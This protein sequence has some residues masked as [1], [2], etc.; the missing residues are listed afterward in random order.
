MADT[1]TLDAAPA[2]SAQTAPVIVAV[3]DGYAQTKL[4]NR[5]ARGAD[6]VTRSLLLTSVRQGSDTFSGLD[7]SAARGS[8]ES[9]GQRFNASPLVA[10]ENTRYDDFHVSALNRVA[11]HHALHESG[12]RGRTVDLICGLPLSSYYSNGRRNVDFINKKKTNLMVPVRALD[13]GPED[14]VT[15]SSV[16]V[17]SQGICAWVDW[18]IDE[19]LQF[20]PEATEEDAP[21]GIIDI[22]GRTTDFAVV[23]LDQG[24]P[25]ID[26][27]RSGSVNLGVLD[28]QRILERE[29]TA[30]FKG[31]EKLARKEYD[32][33]VREGE[34][35]I[36]GRKEDVSDLVDRGVREIGA[37]IERV[38][39]GTIGSGADL[40][41]V[42]FVGGGAQLFQKVS[43]IYP[44]GIVQEDPEFSNARGMF[45]YAALQAGSQG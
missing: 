26:H 24:K 38:V 32:R 18:A 29:I 17:Y 25:R 40:G 30:R 27:A 8:Y 37:Q 2:A 7:G 6:E 15:I 23:I 34:M 31:V 20:R 36:F 44:H 14:N 28:V 3:D 22:G 1:L 11:I 12:F 21:V 10:S 16:S 35:R 39:A 9:E 33:A 5:G 43:Q 42:L 41:A 19:S 13:A 45:K 4:W